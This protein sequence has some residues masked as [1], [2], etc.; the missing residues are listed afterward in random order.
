[1]N[2]ARLLLATCLAASV[3]AAGPTMEVYK[4][5]TCGCCAKWVE[6]MKAA[7]FDVKVNEVDSTGDY[8]KQNGVPESLASCHTAVVEGYALEG[9]VP[10]E[11]V[12]KLLKTRPAGAKGLAVPG[13]PLGSPGMEQ[14]GT[15]RQAYTVVLFDKE[16]KAY[17]FTKYE[18]RQ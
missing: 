10:A 18:S 15:R 7:G 1:M 8:R 6:H 5:R 2:I 3:Y 17:E 11:D 9:H 13:M 4:T 16:G 12:Q 14:A